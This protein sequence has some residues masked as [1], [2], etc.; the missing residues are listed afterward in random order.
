MTEPVSAI[1]NIGPKSVPGFARAG[2]TT[3][4]QV[5]ALGAEEAYRRLIL[6][7]TRPHFIGFYALAMGLQGRLWSDITPDEKA[8]LR[9][10]FDA[11]VAGLGGEAKGRS[12]FEA[13][14]NALGVVGG[15]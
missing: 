15:D 8:E 14:L 3:A 9:V 4:D 11:L 12:D 7:G 5:R 2:L 10:V 1:R 6:A 13:A